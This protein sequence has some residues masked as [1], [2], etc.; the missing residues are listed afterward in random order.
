[1]D[2]VFR[3]LF[4]GGVVPETQAIGLPLMAIPPAARSADMISVVGWPKKCR[5]TPWGR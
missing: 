5:K 2:V 4:E 3:F 1:M